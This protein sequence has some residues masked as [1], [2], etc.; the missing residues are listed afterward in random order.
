LLLMITFPSPI[1]VRLR[2]GQ[3]LTRQS[4]PL[5]LLDVSNE[6]VVYAMLP[7]LTRRVMLWQGA[8]YDAA[9]DYTQAQA[10][11]RLMQVL[12]SNPAA[13]LSE[14]VPVPAPTPLPL[15]LP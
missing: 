8:A 9:G 4:F 1:T 10:E 13:L 6:R 14:P 11:A 7:P 3:N 12:G 5:A 15:P 2:N